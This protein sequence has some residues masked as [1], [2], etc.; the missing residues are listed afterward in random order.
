MNLLNRSGQRMSDRRI[1]LVIDPQN[2]FHGGGSLGKL[3]C[4]ILTY[5]LDPH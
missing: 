2:D 3:L 1:L 4:F 5:T